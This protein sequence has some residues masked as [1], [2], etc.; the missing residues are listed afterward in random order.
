[1]LSD[2]GRRNDLKLIPNIVRNVLEVR[3][4]AIRNYYPP[5]AGAVGRQN[6]FLYAANR[7]DQA[8]KGDLTR[9]RRIG[10]DLAAGVERCKCRSHGNAGA[11][12]VF[13]DRAGRHVEVDAVVFD[14]IGVDTEFDGMRPEIT[15]RR[16]GG[17]LHYVA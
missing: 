9:H 6:L 10:A 3:F 15:S 2:T 1:D 14:D 5:D 7:K 17:F 4:V 12:A 13:W 16:L 11:R 8:R